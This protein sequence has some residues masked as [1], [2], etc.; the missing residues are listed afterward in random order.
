MKT[1]SVLFLT[2]VLAL[3]FAVAADQPQPPTAG[4]PAPAFNLPNQ[5]GAQVS[6]DQF[7]G[8]W[9]VLYFYPKDFTS[10]CTLEAHNFQRDLA[11]YEQTG[12]VILGVSV[13][14]ADSHK[15]FCAK[16]GLNF[17][18]LSDPDAKVTAAYGSAMEYKGSKLAARNT[19]IID[20]EGKI[21]KVYT[22]V[23]PAAH[24]DE[25]LAALAGLQKH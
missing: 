6:L 23:D 3:V 4:N 11:K 9:V 5:E 10:G 13:D 7:K 20:P 25:V 19:F 21:A 2:L 24:S 1:F 18:L 17:T 12:A 14:S 8:K 16:E 15:G 22:Q